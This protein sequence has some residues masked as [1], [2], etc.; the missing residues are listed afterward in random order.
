MA[1]DHRHFVEAMLGYRVAKTRNKPTE[2]DDG[3]QVQFIDKKETDEGP[4][5]VITKVAPATKR[6]Y[7][8]F[9]LLCTP[10]ESW[11]SN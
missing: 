2:Y 8:L 10:Q 4:V 9:E 1:D 11:G 5:E 6:E 3:F 7:Q